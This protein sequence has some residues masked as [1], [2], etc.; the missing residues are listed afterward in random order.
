[1][2]RWKV[3]VLVKGSGREWCSMVHKVG[4]LQPE[5]QELQT[6]LANISNLKTEQFWQEVIK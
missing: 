4:D 1:M 2:V 3:L 6:F 5:I